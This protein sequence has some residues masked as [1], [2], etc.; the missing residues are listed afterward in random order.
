MLIEINLGFTEISFRRVAF[1]KSK[2][3]A[4]TNFIFRFPPKKEKY[5]PVKLGSRLTKF[6]RKVASFASDKN[7]RQWISWEIKHPTKS[8]VARFLQLSEISRTLVKFEWIS[9][10][11]QLQKQFELNSHYEKDASVLASLTWILSRNL[12]LRH[13][14]E[15]SGRRGV[16]PKIILRSFHRKVLFWA[17]LKSDLLWKKPFKYSISSEQLQFFL[18]KFEVL[19]QLSSDLIET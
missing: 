9:E 5:N 16:C 13:I 15:W 17:H 14:L 19:A 12:K 6:I 4:Y 18:E 1:E 10:I 8:A 11:V 7:S 3:E 2:E